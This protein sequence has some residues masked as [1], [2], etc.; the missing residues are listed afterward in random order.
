MQLFHFTNLMR[1]PSIL[2]DGINKGEI[3]ISPTLAYNQ[4]PNAANLTTNGNPADQIVWAN[5]N[6]PTNKLAIRLTVEVPDADLTSFRAVKEKYQIRSSWLKIIAPYEHRRHW[7]FAMNGVKPHQIEKVE[8]LENGQYRQLSHAEV[9]DLVAM[10]DAEANEKLEFTVE[11]TGILAGASAFFLK[12]GVTDSW[13]FDGPEFR[14]VRFGTRP[15]YPWSNR[16]TKT[17]GS[18]TSA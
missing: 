14:A 11:K 6:N 4:L 3:P 15:A 1:L 16:E 12:P 7:Y 17:F 13:L 9:Q 2:R 5:S 8:V 10:I 18:T